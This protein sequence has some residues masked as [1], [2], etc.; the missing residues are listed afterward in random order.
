[1]SH[2]F[3]P[4]RLADQVLGRLGDQILSRATGIGSYALRQAKGL[5]KQAAWIA[6]AT[7]ALAC[8]W[9]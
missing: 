8:S 3:D 6:E 7:A 1:M 9:A 4:D 2:P 5:A